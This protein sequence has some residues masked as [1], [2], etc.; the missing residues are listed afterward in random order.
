MRERGSPSLFGNLTNSLEI[1]HLA[2]L[3][4]MGGEF[5]AFENADVVVHLAGRAHVMRET[6]KDPISEFRKVNVDGTQSMVQSALRYGVQR[7][8]YI[9]SIKVNGEETKGRAFTAD[10][11]PG[12][13]DPYG[14]SKWEAEESLKEI[15]KGSTLEWV[16]VRPP[17]VYGPGV[18]GNFLSL[19]NLAYRGIPLPLGSVRNRRTLVSVYNLCD[20]LCVLVDHP[21]AAN[22]CFLVGDT[23]DLSTPDL[24]RAVGTALGR[25]PRIVAFPPSLLLKFSR[26]LGKEGVMQ[27]LCSSL[28]VDRQKTSVFLDWRAPLSFND[29]L[30]RTAEWFLASR[31]QKHSQALS[32]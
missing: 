5:K 8:L 30:Q 20:L 27:R 7:F 13:V 15:T 10:D 18:R 11:P 26:L 19:L 1:R 25:S 4:A 24:I 9:S 28:I 16:I 3:N 21:A 14:Q 17:L 32:N 22:Q 23:E 2:D 31:E 29:G 12:F 6:Q